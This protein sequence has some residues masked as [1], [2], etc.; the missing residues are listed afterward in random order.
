[1]SE[2]TYIKCDGCGAISPWC[3]DDGAVEREMEGWLEVFGICK[4]TGFDRQP[5][6]Y[7]PRCAEKLRKAVRSLP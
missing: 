1:M 5:R 4:E 7:C 6:D 2:A 3:R